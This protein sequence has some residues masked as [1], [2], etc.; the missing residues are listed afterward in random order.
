MQ[1]FIVDDDV[2]F[3][4]SLK[5]ML[6]AR[7]LKTVLFESPQAFLDSIP[8]DQR[9]IAIV[10]IYMPDFDGFFLMDKMKELHYRMPVIVVTGHCQA[11]SRDRAMER[12]AVGFLQK[13]FNERSLLALIEEQMEVENKNLTEGLDTKLQ[14]Q[15]QEGGKIRN[16]R[17][18]D[19]I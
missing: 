9:G 17:D 10:D 19:A 7:E 1:I 3:G 15:H 13:P 12:G 5:L 11:D 4:R 8:Y 2:S 18:N 6:D 16:P 14:K